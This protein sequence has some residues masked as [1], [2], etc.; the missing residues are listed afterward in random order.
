M[1]KKL[2]KVIFV[3]LIQVFLWSGISSVAPLIM[4]YLNNDPKWAGLVP[5][6]NAV[7]Y[8]MKRFLDESKKPAV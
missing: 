7:L 5:V 3:D 1:N 2:L 4:A 6:I 8:G